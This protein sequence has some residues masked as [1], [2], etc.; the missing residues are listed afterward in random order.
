MLD[1]WKLAEDPV[2]FARTLLNFTP[3]PYQE[4]VL[5]DKSKRIIICAGR[6]VGKSTIIAI[7]ALHFALTNPGTTTLIVSATLRQSM[8]M[9][10]KIIDFIEYSPLIKRSVTYRS[11]TRVRFSNRSWII[12][13]PCGRK[14]D[15]LRGFTAHLIIFDEAAFIPEEVITNVALPMIATTNGSVWMLSSPWD[16]DHI[17]YRIWVRGEE[18]SKYHFPS[19]VN[20]LI[21]KEF[22][23]EQ[24]QLV[25][26]ERFAVEYLAEF[27]EE[28]SSYFPMKLL[29][30]AV[31]DASDTV[32]GVLEA[33]YDPGGKDSKAALVIVEKIGENEIIVRTHRTWKGMDYTTMNVEVAEI[34]KREGVQ[35]LRVDQTGLGN[36][37]VEH[38][39]EL[40]LP[41]EGV[42]LTPA[43]KEEI[44]LNL[45][46]FLEETASGGTRR[47]VLPPSP[48][49]LNHLNA[50]TYRRTRAGRYEFDKREGTY[51]DLAYAL[52]LA[53]MRSEAP[54]M[55][56]KV[57]V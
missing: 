14:G 45:R 32:R 12:A 3:F 31:G 4:A 23:E 54:F 11:R 22:L 38:L 51:D 9:F 36:P 35:R 48:E 26:E 50:V 16:T 13:L 33:G 20:P 39:R 52:A 44:F 1:V 5:R 56:R 40:G 41:V 2:Y 10:D 42:T 49:L 34:C 8:L 25:G 7:K 18:W 55:V 21:S 57:R 19:N 37:I 46:L 43:K 6:Q 17:F 53:C 24:R 30:S 47:I 27:R 28:E 15:T 29:R